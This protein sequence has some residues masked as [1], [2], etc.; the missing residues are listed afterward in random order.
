MSMHYTKEHEWVRV[1]GDTATI[2]ISVY[3]QE[4]LGE[5]VFVELPDVGTQLE[6]G[7]QAAVIES[8]KAASEIYAPVS[9]KVTETNGD[10][11]AEPSKVNDDATGEGWL[12]KVSL[13]DTSELEDMLNEGDYMGYV[14]GLG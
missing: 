1:E 8:V 2:G 11:D 9:G 4:Q 3:A 13:S 12:F 7:S 5:I 14:E 6:R 10:L